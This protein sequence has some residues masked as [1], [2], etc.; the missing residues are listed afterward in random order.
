MKRFQKKILPICILL[1]AV[2]AVLVWYH[3]PIKSTAT[4]ELYCDDP[5]VRGLCAEFDLKLSRSLFSPLAINGTIRIGD[6][7]YVVWERQDYGFFSDIQR[8]A[9]G[10]LDIP[11]FINAANFGKG[12]NL[13]IRDLLYIHSIQFGDHHMIEHV[14]LSLTSDDH[15]MWNSRIVTS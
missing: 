12:T 5:N 7:D 3:L 14:S 4:V 11:V 10:E 2:A 1:V 6:R 9:N 8:K 13:L 15:G